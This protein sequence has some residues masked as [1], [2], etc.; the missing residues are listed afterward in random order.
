MGYQK[1]QGGSCDRGLSQL[2]IYFDSVHLF[3]E[4]SID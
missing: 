2:L 1:K 4:T 3:T